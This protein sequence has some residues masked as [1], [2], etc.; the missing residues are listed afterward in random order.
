MS[1]PLDLLITRRDVND[2]VIYKLYM[3]NTCTCI[4]QYKSP[5]THRNRQS[6]KLVNATLFTII[7]SVIYFH[8]IVTPTSASYTLTILSYAIQWIICHTIL[9]AT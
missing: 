6:L 9:Y 7:I 2:N 4:Q 8:L 3:E 1:F 5:T